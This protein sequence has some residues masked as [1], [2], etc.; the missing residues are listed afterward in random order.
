MHS[1]FL[2]IRSARDEEFRSADHRTPYMST[3]GSMTGEVDSSSI[4]PQSASRWTSKEHQPGYLRNMK[5]SSREKIDSSMPTTGEINAE[6]GLSRAPQAP[7]DFMKAERDKHAAEFARHSRFPASILP[8]TQIRGTTAQIGDFFD[9]MALAEIDNAELF[10]DL[11]FFGPPPEPRVEGG[12]D[13]DP[14]PYW[15]LSVERCEFFS[16]GVFIKQPS[17]PE[18]PTVQ[19]NLER[20][21]ELKKQGVHFNENLMRNRSFKNPHVYSQLVEFLGIDETRSN[22]SCLDTGRGEAGSWRAMLPLSE[23]ELIEGDPIATLEK[24]Q[25]DHRDKQMEKLKAGHKR[26]IDFSRGQYEDT[27]DGPSLRSASSWEEPS[28]SATGSKPGHQADDRKRTA[29]SNRDSDA[30]RRFSIADQHL[31]SSQNRSKRH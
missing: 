15:G 14:R 9:P 10:R 5:E 28:R 23:Q 4:N 11:P 8:Q 31:R 27:D 16:N 2:R 7:V 25:Q 1:E 13:P 12:V 21:H 26:T 22:L 30:K 3:V 6:A 17:I 19:A 24:Q 29:Q 20:Y 18:N